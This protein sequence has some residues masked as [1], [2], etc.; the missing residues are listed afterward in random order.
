[1]AHNCDEKTCDIGAP[2]NRIVPEAWSPG[3]MLSWR[4]VWHVDDGH[5]KQRRL[6]QKVLVAPR[7]TASGSDIQGFR[8]IRGPW[9]EAPI[10]PGGT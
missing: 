7:P 6:A 4:G 5:L 1:M 10:M 3:V 2:I 9:A 8:S